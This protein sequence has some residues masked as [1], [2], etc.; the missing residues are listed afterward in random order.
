[1]SKKATGRRQLASA[2]KSRL[3]LSRMT[4][5]N[6]SPKASETVRGGMAPKPYPET[7]CRTCGC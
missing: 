7:R 2:P 5:K 3:S 1:M 4:L 6:L